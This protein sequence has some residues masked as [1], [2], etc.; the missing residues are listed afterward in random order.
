M[1]K[2]KLRKGTHGYINVQVPEVMREEL[3][4]VAGEDVEMKREGT[5]LIIEKLGVRRYGEK[6][7]INNMNNLEVVQI[8]ES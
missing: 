2:R 3:G 7:S 8:V 1:V 6:D 5:K 4:W